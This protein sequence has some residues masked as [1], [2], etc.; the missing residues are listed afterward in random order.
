MIKGNVGNIVVVPSQR[1]YTVKQA[2]EILNC[3]MGQKKLYQFLRDQ[4][5]IESSEDLWHNNQPFSEYQDKDYV[6]GK[7]KEYGKETIQNCGWQVYISESGI[8]FLR[9]LISKFNKLYKDDE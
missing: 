3:G 8:D 6:K 1:W 2:A 7:F 5:I 4:Q 9:E